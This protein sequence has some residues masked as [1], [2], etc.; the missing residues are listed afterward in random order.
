[1]T[2]GFGWKTESLNRKIRSRKVERVDS[3]GFSWKPIETSCKY[4]EVF[5]WCGCS[6]KLSTHQFSHSN[7]NRT[8]K[9]FNINLFQIRVL[10]SSQ[11][12][13]I[14][15]LVWGDKMEE[16]ILLAKCWMK[17]NDWGLLIQIVLNLQQFLE[18]LCHS[19]L[20]S[21]NEKLDL[22]SLINNT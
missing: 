9:F 13:R 4:L 15:G 8:M 16:C 7:S 19:Q 11:N 1:M 21:L 10:A 18:A 12:Y 17:I 6:I 2:G 14:F 3:K 20:N 5:W 22:S